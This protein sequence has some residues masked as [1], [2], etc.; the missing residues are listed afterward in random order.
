MTVSQTQPIQ[1]YYW[2][3]PNGRKITVALEE[4]GVPYDVTFIDLSRREQFKP[5]FSAI[6]P[7]HQIPAIVDPEG[8][9]GA[10]ISVFQ[11]GAILLYLGRKFGQI[12][13]TDE[14]ARV[15][16]DTWLMFQMGDFGPLLGQAHHFNLAAP[17]DVPYAIERYH[18]VAQRLYTTLNERLSG[19]DFV[20]GDFSIADIALYCWAA[21]HERHR[22]DL[23]DYPDVKRWFDVISARPAVQRGMAV[24]KP[25]HVDKA[26]VNPLRQR[27]H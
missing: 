1:L 15:E 16:V 17:V 12:Y 14:R 11:S 18:K 26:V 21:R 7:N 9:G 27:K 20:A 13:P 6:S 2:S 4:L 25:G 24:A 22:I 10:P 19:R 5:E 8:P 23:A 3:T